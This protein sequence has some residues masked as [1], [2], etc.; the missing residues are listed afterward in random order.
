MQ[1]KRQMEKVNRGEAYYTAE[2]TAW[3]GY[4]LITRDITS[5]PNNDKEAVLS[6]NV[7]NTFEDLPHAEGESYE[8]SSYSAGTPLTLKTTQPFDSAQTIIRRLS[9]DGLQYRYLPNPLLSHCGIV[10]GEKSQL[11]KKRYRICLVEPK[12]TPP[13]PFGITHVGT[14]L[15]DMRSSASSYAGSGMIGRGVA[16][17]PDGKIL[18]AGMMSSNIGSLIG[19][20]VPSYTWNV[21]RFHSDGSVDRTFGDHGI[22]ETDLLGE[23]SPLSL[24]LLKDGKF[25][26]GGYGQTKSVHEQ[27]IVVR[28]LPDGNKDTTFGNGGI[29]EVT[30]LDWTAEDTVPR[31]FAMIQQED[32]KVVMGGSRAG[33][34]FAVG[35]MLENGKLDTSF[36]KDGWSVTNLGHSVNSSTSR[37]ALHNIFLAPDGKI[38]AVGSTDII[39]PDCTSLNSTYVMAVV[40]YNQDGSLDSGFG[41][42]G[43]QKMW[44]SGETE[45]NALTV[46]TA[47]LFMSDGKILIGG[48]VTYRSVLLTTRG[49]DVGLVRLLANGKTDA[50][51]GKDGFVTFDGK[52]PNDTQAERVDE[53]ITEMAFVEGDKI[54]A[55]GRSVVINGNGSDATWDRNGLIF[56]RYLTDGNLDNTFGTNGVLYSK[57]APDYNSGVDS[58]RSPEVTRLL[59]LPDKKFLVAGNPVNPGFPFLGR[60]LSDGKADSLF[61]EDGFVRFT[62]GFSRDTA[63]AVAFQPDGKVVLAGNARSVYS[64]K[65]ALARVNPDA[66]LDADFG[67]FAD[68]CNIACNRE[69]L[70]GRARQCNASPPS[71]EWGQA[72]AIQPDG[73][74]VVGGVSNE[75]KNPMVARYLSNGKLDPSFG[76]NGVKKTDTEFNLAAGGTGLAV[77][78]TS[79]GNIV[80]GGGGKDGQWYLARFLPNGMTDTSFG[81]GGAT[82]TTFQIKGKNAKGSLYSILPISDGKLVV[83]GYLMVPPTP[84][85]MGMS[86]TIYDFAVVRYLANGRLDTSFGENGFTRTDFSDIWKSDTNPKMPNTSAPKETFDQAYALALQ[87]DGKIILGGCSQ[88]PGAAVLNPNP[89]S[90]ISV[91]YW[92]AL[93]RYLPNGSIDKS[94]GT[95]GKVIRDFSKD[96]ADNDYSKSHCI[97]GLVVHSD[98]RIAVAP[99]PHN[100]GRQGYGGDNRE[101]IHDKKNVILLAVFTADGALDKSVG[102][103]GIF[104]TDIGHYHSEARALALSKSGVIA[105]A[106]MTIR[107]VQQTDFFVDLWQIGASK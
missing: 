78:L 1:I 82:K 7:Q 92:A 75:F 95:H 60:F 48:R 54:L 9:P 64:E 99:S 85:G 55:T 58:I 84:M 94:F 91:W 19:V 101:H 96:L 35:R 100:T 31:I 44:I 11:S 98:G 104:K 77:A 32:G 36:G 63:E 3:H 51:F 86:D 5:D 23:A 38:L 105:I 45:P 10:S 37:D 70:P 79:T 90:G 15:I 66:K 62:F 57:L 89:N 59:L 6:V 76:T 103:N 93:A 73:K 80:L 88:N 49:Q 71:P 69:P 28:Y 87:S 53:Y 21:T 61:S 106:G 40:R 56:L 13:P 2:I 52:L 39:C 72:V 107:T 12:I 27:F 25:L 8:P 16:V 30:P 68:H 43:I 83:A 22:I 20:T 42:G 4:H 74:I 29:A 50:S 102:A 46:A 14:K 34:D 65:L 18:V 41:D 81:D 33:V 67:N 17:Q 47:A 97:M 24:L 26:V